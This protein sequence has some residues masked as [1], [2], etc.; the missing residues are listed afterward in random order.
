M[1]SSVVE[2][3]RSSKT[4]PKV[5]LAP[6]K[7]IITVWWSAAG[8]MHDSFL[9]PGETITSEKCAQQIDAGHRKLQHLWPVLNDRAGP[10]LLE[11]PRLT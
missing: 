10:G 6:K 4:L 3:R 2:W 11:N 7:V 9:D 1:T 8:V 5:K